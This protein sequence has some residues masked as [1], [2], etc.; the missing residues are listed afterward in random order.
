MKIERLMY[1]I[2]MLL[3]KK[4]ILAKDIASQFQVSTRTIYRDIDTLSLLGIPIYSER[5]NNGGFYLADNYKMDSFLFTEEEQKII[6]N[7]SQS[8]SNTTKIPVIEMLK[9][10]MRLSIPLNTTKETYFFDFSLWTTNKTTFNKIESA[11]DNSLTVR[12]KY[13][14]FNN[15]ESIREIEPINLVY[16][17]H[18]WY[19]YGFCKKRQDLRLFR[20]SRIR[21]LEILDIIFDDSNY[22]SINEEAF[23]KILSNLKDSTLFDLVELEFSKNIKS[24]VYDTFSEEVI[25]ELENK[26]I[27]KK[28]MP[29]DDWFIGLILSFR[30]E[31]KVIKPLALKYSIK[32]AALEI[33]TQYDMM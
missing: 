16:K 32:K 21:N 31:V 25:T 6:L 23:N 30:G 5:G 26:L 17:S 22:Q 33:L 2:I 7:I 27:V 19:L 18:T 12:L 13:T 24:K 15:V 3:S 11:I 8:I 29:I 14:S 4:Q 28:N 20:L 10:K 1:I 9:E